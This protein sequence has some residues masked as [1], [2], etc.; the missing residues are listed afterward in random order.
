MRSDTACAPFCALCGTS[1][2]NPQSYRVTDMSTLQKLVKER[3]VPTAFHYQSLMQI[4]PEKRYPLCMAC[5]NWMSRAQ[6]I[7]R[8]KSHRKRAVRETYTPLDSILMYAFVPG[9]S[10]EPDQRSLERLAAV[11]CEENNGFSAIIPVEIRQILDDSQDYGKDMI[12]TSLLFAWWRA[13]EKTMFFRH[14][15]TARAIRHTCVIDDPTQILA[16]K[17]WKR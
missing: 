15:E 6:L 12:D 9:H 13:N 4:A 5:V 3:C 16:R 7:L 14:P 17:R 11:A 2:K 1:C 8:K 10:H